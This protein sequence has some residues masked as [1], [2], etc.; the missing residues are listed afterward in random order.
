MSKG[1]NILKEHGVDITKE[2]YLELEKQ[3]EKKIASGFSTSDFLVNEIISR[4]FFKYFSSDKVKDFLYENTDFYVDALNE[5]FEFLLPIAS[6]CSN[7]YCKEFVYSDYFGHFRGNAK[8]ADSSNVY[9][10]IIICDIADKHNKPTV[11]SVIC[12]IYEDEPCENLL[13]V[14]FAFLTDNEGTYVGELGDILEK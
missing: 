7:V 11:K 9:L 2:E 8:L 6:K 4:Y 3:L 13:D 14:K 12:L 1:F 10:D 5:C